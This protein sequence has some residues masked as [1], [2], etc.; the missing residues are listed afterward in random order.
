MNKTICPVISRTGFKQNTNQICWNDD[1]WH[2]HATSALPLYSIS[3][4]SPFDCYVSEPKEN[5]VN[6]TLCRSWLLVLPHL[7]S[8][9]THLPWATLCQSRPQPYARVDLNPIPESTLSPNKGLSIFFLDFFFLDFFFLFVQYSALLHLQPV[10][11]HCADGCWDR[12]QRW[13]SQRKK[14]HRLAYGF[15]IDFKI[16]RLAYGFLCVNHKGMA[17]VYR[18]L[19]V[20]HRERI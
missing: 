7:T 5:M 6:G 13:K 2:K 10:R 4:A 15:S 14:I 19:V 20:Y 17:K 8:T 1:L 18:F 3:S 11:F 16:Y 9:P 12:T